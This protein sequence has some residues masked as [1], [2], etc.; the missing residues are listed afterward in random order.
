MCMCVFVYA[1]VRCITISNGKFQKMFVVDGSIIKLNQSQILYFVIGGW[2]I[3]CAFLV[4]SVDD[5]DPISM[6]I[7]L[8]H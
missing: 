4:Q 2:W 6:V 7:C 8:G 1:C 5:R 3:K